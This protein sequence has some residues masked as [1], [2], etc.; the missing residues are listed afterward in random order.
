VIWADDDLVATTGAVDSVKAA[1]PD[2]RVVHLTGGHF[3]P[4][5]S[6]SQMAQ[7]INDLLA[8]RTGG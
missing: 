3:S 8:G 6:P 4:E 1:F 2:A 7:A 5:E